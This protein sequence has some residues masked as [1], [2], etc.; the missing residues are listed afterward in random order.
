MG[1]KLDDYVLFATQIF[2]GLPDVLQKFFRHTH[3]TFVIMKWGNQI[4]NARTMG[5]T[6][7]I[8]Q[9]ADGLCSADLNAIYLTGDDHFL[10]DLLFNDFV[11][12]NLYFHAPVELAPFLC[13]IT[14]DRMAISK[15]LIGDG[16]RGKIQ[17]ALAIFCDGARPFTRQPDIIAVKLY[18]VSLER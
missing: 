10:F 8:T 13:R 7:L 3:H 1:G 4:F 17:R 5:V 9:F 6:I 2:H 18:Q 14:Y 11:I 12:P 15:P 16:F